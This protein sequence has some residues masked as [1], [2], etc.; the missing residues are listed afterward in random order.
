[1][2]K[3]S[4]RG[5]IIKKFVIMFSVYALATLIVSAA[6][7]YM[8]QTRSYQAECEN[9]IRNLTNYLSASIENEG[10]DFYKLKQYYEEHS[11]E[12]LIP[13]D[14]AGDYYLD[15]QEFY[16]HF[17]ERYPGKMYGVDITFDE[18][19]EDIKLECAE[20]MFKYWLSV[21]EKARDEFGLKYTY[22]IYPTTEPYMCYMIDAVREEKVVD[23]RTYI[24]LGDT[25]EEDPSEYVMMWEAWNTGK[26]PSGFDVFD[27]EYGHTFAYYSPVYIN[28]EEIGLVCADISVDKVNDSILVAVAGL[29][30]G[31]VLVL[32]IGIIIMVIIIRKN[33]LM[34]IIGLEKNVV[35]YTEE[36][37]EAIAEEIRKGDSGN[38]E[39]KNLSEHFADMIG[40]LKDYM[41]NLQKVTA[42]KERIGAE[43]NVATQIQ[44]DM[45]PRIF[46]PF[47]ERGEFDIYATMTPAKEVGGDFYDFFL[48]DDDHIGLVMA[49]VSGKGVP[50][51]LFMVIAK[52]L[53]KNRALLGGSPSEVLSYAND[54]L[55]EGNEAE[56]FVTVWFGI[57]QISTGKGVAANAGHEHPVVRR[58]DG[59]FELV[60]YRHSPAV[61]T[62][63]GIPFKQHDFELNPGDTLFVYTDGV[64]EATNAQDELYGT[65]R[66]LEALNKN[67]NA[68]AK[69]MLANVKASIDEFVGDAPQF[70]DI[71]M[72]GFNYF[73]KG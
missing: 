59:E 70:D 30:G 39:I 66:M 20:Y 64:A 53:I 10:E 11:D 18:L 28:G 60:V 71:T 1:M 51:A 55:C 9:N 32:L 47:P 37:D 21:F 49:D 31:S 57:L 52:T 7:T 15:E 50:A 16:L 69:E 29:L 13:I 62:M 56:L 17:S 58:K 3:N 34:R 40:E 61:A 22:F 45:L 35:R 33:F 46:P 68:D 44:A 54:Q 25:V 23:G 48:I 26:N 4:K 73:G 6:F 12:M 42:E 63:E 5:S 19:D 67:P 72:L 41:T 36:K 27:N 2:K 65:D 43:L 24:S 14:Y 8:N 38:D